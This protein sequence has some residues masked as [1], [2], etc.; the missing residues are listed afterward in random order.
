MKSSD[1]ILVL[2][3]VPEFHPRLLQ[4]ARELVREDGS[5]DCEKVAFYRKE[6][7]EAVA[8]AQ[9]YAQATRKAVLCLKEIA[10]S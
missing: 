8:E 10:R 4:L 5:I 6:I 9:E 2:K 1:L 7:E 3:E